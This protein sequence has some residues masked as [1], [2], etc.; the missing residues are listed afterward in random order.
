MLAETVHHTGQI[1]D[2][3]KLGPLMAYVIQVFESTDK[4]KRLFDDVCFTDVITTEPLLSAYHYLQS[5]SNVVT[6]AGYVG[7]ADTQAPQA[8]DVPDSLV[9][10]RPNKMDRDL[11]VIV[12]VLIWY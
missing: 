12:Y 6:E 11:E 10:C 1:S 8:A 7:A 3:L 9:A 4:L 2:G 5:H